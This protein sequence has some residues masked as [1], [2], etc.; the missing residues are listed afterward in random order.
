MSSSRDTPLKRAEQAVIRAAVG[1]IGKQGFSF[2]I[3]TESITRTYFI[4]EDAHH[5]L[6]RAVAR[7]KEARRKK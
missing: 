1:C 6:E 2:R 5:R 4:N 7:L 3:A